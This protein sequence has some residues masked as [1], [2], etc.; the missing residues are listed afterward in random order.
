MK[1]TSTIANTLWTATNLPFYLRFRQSLLNPERI[2]TRILQDYI[3]RNRHT[4]FAKAHH[5]ESIRTYDDFINQVPLS[6]YESTEPWINRIC[7]GETNV[8]TG[9]PVTRLIPTSGSSGPRKLIPFTAS[10]QREFNA[11]I[12]AWLF[13][14]WR[15]RPAILGG[16]SY[17]SIT[18]VLS[19]TQNETATVPIGFD[20]DVSY[21][22][23]TRR[24]L[25]NA[26]M[27][28]PPE[29]GKIS[30]LEA[31]RYVTLLLLMREADLRVISV[32]HPSFLTLLLDSLRDHFDELI[33]DIRTGRCRY[34]GEIPA[35]NLKPDPKRAAQLQSANAKHPATIWP[36]LQAISCWG[37]AA[38]ESSCRALEEAFPTIMVQRKGLLATEAFVTI[39]FVGQKPVAITSHFF[40][41][42]DSKGS[43]QRVHELT[44][45]ETYE[46]VVTTSG[47]LWRYRLGDRVVV[48]GFCNECPSLVFIGRTEDVSDLCGE[49]L[50][51]TF[52]K[53]ALDE[54]FGRL[55][56][57]FLM[58]APDH[59][60]GGARYT[61]YVEGEVPQGIENVLDS[62]LRR[63]PNYAYCRDLGQLKPLELI[64]TR[65]GGYSTYVDHMARKGRRVGDIKPVALSTITNWRD[66]FKAVEKHDQ[67]SWPS[68]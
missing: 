20:T 33:C 3:H 64:R 59:H 66:V 8:L 68:G 45:G 31:F 13:D 15:Q 67:L 10:L 48:D 1:P 63:N 22:S 11:A 58:L 9:D 60:E 4:A 41:F 12:G 54:A 57:R 46:V 55:W 23:G 43:I 38:A 35:F 49:K 17:W 61:L 40:E 19:Q 39:P 36:N 65:V 16:P 44:E 25:A 53:E 56:P 24:R 47:G 62:I 26:V 29:V 30:K 18:P 50:S 52:V 32:W 21:L 5:F 2:Q 34:Q 42:I 37:D 28:V 51:E 7:R 27:A 6:H 14:L